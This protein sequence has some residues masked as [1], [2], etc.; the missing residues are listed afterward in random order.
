MPIF[1]KKSN[2]VYSVTT[3]D[4][5]NGAI[6]I[7]SNTVSTANTVLVRENDPTK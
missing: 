1:I 2:N 3:I 7:S 4:P 5:N 6:I